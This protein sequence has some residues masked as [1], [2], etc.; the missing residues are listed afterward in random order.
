[1]AG[2]MLTV[3]AL[4]LWL[5][6]SSA[7]AASEQPPE[8]AFECDA[9]DGDSDCD[10]QAELYR[11]SLLQRQ[12]GAK[13]QSRS[14]R[15]PQASK[16]AS[17]EALR[18]KR[19][20]LLTELAEIDEALDAPAQRADGAASCG[21]AVGRCKGAVDWA[22]TTGI[23]I[24]P[25]WYPG[26][27]GASSRDD[28]QSVLASKHMSGCPTPCT[29][30][31]DGAATPPATGASTC[32]AI[33]C[34][35]NYKPQNACQCTSACGR[36]NNCCAD[37]QQTCVT[38]EQI[39][40]TVVLEPFL[41]IG[42]TP[43]PNKYRKD[44]VCDDFM[45]EWSEPIWGKSGRNDLQTIKDMGANA[46]RTYG[47][48]SHLDHRK[49]L[50]HAHAVGLKVLPGFADYPYLHLGSSCSIEH[51]ASWLPTNCIRGRDHNCF[52]IIKAHYV[53]ML[54][55]GYTIVDGNG[56]RRYHPAISIVTV[57]NE[58]ELKLQYN[59]HEGLGAN[60]NHA[61][62]VVTATDGILSAEEELGIVGPRPLLTATA[63]YAA[64]P[65]C[66]SVHMGFAGLRGNVP[67][68]PW[69]SD[70]YLAFK[71]P[72]GFIGYAPENDLMSMYTSRWVNSFN[73]PRPAAS[74]CE[75]ENRALEM[76]TQSPL[77]KVPIYIGEFHNS[78]LSPYAFGQ[79][80]LKAK[81]IRDNTDNGSCGVAKN[82][83]VGFNLF[84]FQVSYWKGAHS[85]GGTAMRYGFWGLGWNKVARTHSDQYSIGWSQYD[86]FCI[87]PATPNGGNAGGGPSNAAEIVKV[88]GGKM[89]PR[90]KLC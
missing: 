49:F 35:G 30:G 42:Y 41:G 75:T 50:D 17:E 63:S 86:V 56:T 76:Y 78:F 85:E 40:S 33:G 21:P 51:K 24:H 43:D 37:Y 64:C 53:E 36:F 72:R 23:R 44:P 20:A 16:A 11:V 48:G 5:L 83:L 54:K 28:F 32:K 3:L 47:I 38:G 65:N 59:N 90:P 22:K 60:A 10:A 31:G 8:A 45:A 80:I 77:G 69:V 84:E 34:G 71:D 2:S 52:N 89:P 61:K 87:F 88:L 9:S 79:D 26:L 62:V 15:P 57:I 27:S 74:L 73:T 1:M 12:G 14:P 82:P 29:A 25:E 66:K 67:F 39:N 13:F 46:I 58:C 68:L 55:K 6:P 18:E 4:V 81:A 19:A 70:Y 7:V